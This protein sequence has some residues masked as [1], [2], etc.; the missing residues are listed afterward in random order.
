MFNFCYVVFH[1]SFQVLKLLYHYCSQN[2]QT[3]L[4]CQRNQITICFFGCLS[5]RIQLATIF[6]NN[7]GSMWYYYSSR[8]HPLIFTNKLFH[9]MEPCIKMLFLFSE[10]LKRSSLYASIRISFLSAVLRGASS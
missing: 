10:Q 8:N 7:N 4:K 6:Q 1:W 2:V 9:V 5:C 3:P